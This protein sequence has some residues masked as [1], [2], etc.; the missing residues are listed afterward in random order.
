MPGIGPITA[1]VL[2][3]TLPN[4]SAFRSDPA[5]G[6][7]RSCALPEP[8]CLGPRT[9]SRHVLG[10]REGDLAQPG[11]A[12]RGGGRRYSTDTAC[13][14]TCR[15][16]GRLRLPHHDKR[17]RRGGGGSA[18]MLRRLPCRKGR[19]RP[20]HSRAGSHCPRYLTRRRG[21]QAMI[22]DDQSATFPHFC[23][24]ERRS[25]FIALGLF[26]F[27]CLQGRM[28][29]AAFGTALFVFSFFGTAVWAAVR[30][31]FLVSS[32]SI[33]ERRGCSLGMEAPRDRQCGHGDT[34]R[35]SWRQRRQHTVFVLS[36]LL[37]LGR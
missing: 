37:A 22:W 29:A 35:R 7:F 8:G 15:S 21:H 23:L 10:R 4:V 24:Q 3:A 12:G 9:Q 32:L 2:A 28:R 1:S 27:S 30:R 17:E 25:R 5:L 14:R 6:R 34:T 33:P 18:V 36:D 16:A 31:R 13:W 19:R 26:L 20:I 11:A